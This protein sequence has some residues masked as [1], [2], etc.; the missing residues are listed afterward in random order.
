MEKLLNF[1]ERT[2]EEVARIFS[3]DKYY[4]CS[5]LPPSA[6][7]TAWVAMAGN[8]A[9][10]AGP[11]FPQCVRW[12]IANQSKEGFWGE[13]SDRGLDSIA[14]TLASL[15]ALIRWNTGHANVQR[16]RYIYMQLLKVR[17]LYLK[18]LDPL[19]INLV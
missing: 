3:D 1:K 7:D 13:S 8:V 12:I 4:C 15:L 17:I 9:G 19:Y 11:L 14:A 6:Y 2:R 5:L 16:G 18:I 10:A